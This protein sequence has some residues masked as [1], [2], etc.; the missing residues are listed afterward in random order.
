MPALLKKEESMKRNLLVVSILVGIV[1]LFFAAL[2]VVGFLFDLLPVG[3]IG[4]VMFVI[5]LWVFAGSVFRE[6]V[7]LKFERL[8]DDGNYPAAAELLDKASKN[9]LLY[10]IARVV[11]YQLYIRAE[12]AL[13]EVGA[14][15]KYVEC[16]RHAGGTGWKYRTA[17]Y[18]ILF[19]LDWNDVERA[20]EE[21]E[22]FYADC[23]QSAVYRVQIEIL[24]G[25][26]AH[27]DGKEVELPKEAYRSP[28]PVVKRVLQKYC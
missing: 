18:V 4:A 13:D 11:V 3:I 8:F 22:A 27:I 6:R 25:I 1:A 9:H 19:H 24:Q 16:L 12:L 23:A 28:Y 26:F 21:F 20:R 10:P 7:Y 15:A 14:A 5:S 17:Y 2:T